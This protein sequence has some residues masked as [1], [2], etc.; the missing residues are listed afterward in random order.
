M[1]LHKLRFGEETEYYVASLPA[2]SLQQHIM[3]MNNSTGLRELYE[4][5]SITENA[6]ILIAIVLSLNT[7]ISSNIYLI[8]I[9]IIKPVI[10]CLV[11]TDLCINS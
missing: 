2:P 3:F 6:I 7:C 1:N 8:C 10:T 11:G 5:T 9:K 4:Q